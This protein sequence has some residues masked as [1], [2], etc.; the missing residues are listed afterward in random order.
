MDNGGFYLNLI[1]KGAEAYLYKDSWFGRDVIKKVRISKKYRDPKLDMKIRDS[2]TINE[3]KIIT[4]ARKNGVFTPYIYE[5]DVKNHTI[6][7][8]F[9]NGQRI[10][11]I[12]KPNNIE[13]FIKIGKQVGL[14]HQ[15]NLIHGD[16][17]T[18]N[19]ILLNGNDIFFIDFG[20]ASFSTSIESFGVDIHLMKRALNSTHPE[21]AEKCYELFLKGYEKQFPNKFN[22]IKNKI[23]EI[24]SRGRY[25]DRKEDN[26][27][28]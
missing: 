18:S 19:M 24:E 25:I 27:D 22:E 8:D 7:M 28:R 13:I 16:L 9:L 15:N 3:A 14:L 2:R 23:K 10:K 11:E 17:T 4:E 21:L 12:L 1:R 20:L 26:D 5:I 6:V